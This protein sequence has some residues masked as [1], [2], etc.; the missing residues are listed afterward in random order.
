MHCSW[1][2]GRLDLPWPCN[3]NEFL[4][5]LLLINLSIYP[6]LALKSDM[7]RVLAAILA[8]FR[9]KLLVTGRRRCWANHTKL[10]SF[11]S[12][13]GY[14]AASI[15]FSFNGKPRLPSA[16]NLP[17]CAFYVCKFEVIS[18]TP[19]RC[20]FAGHCTL[21]EKNLHF[22]TQFQ[23][24]S[25][26]ICCSTFGNTTAMCYESVNIWKTLL[27]FLCYLCSRLSVIRQ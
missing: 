18:G 19:H 15:L 13:A 6:L 7:P 26:G 3:R 9:I 16:F 5:W 20:L 23:E 2:V 8:C 27:S 14:L 1:L 21:H 17:S 11:A 24:S 25:T 22:V 12:R 4:T 10:L